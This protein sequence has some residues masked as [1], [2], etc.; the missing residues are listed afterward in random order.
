MDLVG[1]NLEQ[2]EITSED[3]A[4]SRCK[5][6]GGYNIIV[7]VKWEGESRSLTKFENRIDVRNRR[8]GST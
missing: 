8:I 7:S 1:E 3:C 6:S 5:N 4:P 2:K